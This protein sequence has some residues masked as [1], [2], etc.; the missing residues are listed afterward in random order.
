MSVNFDESTISYIVGG[1]KLG[2]AFNFTPGTELYPS[3]LIGPSPGGQTVEWIGVSWEILPLVY[4]EL[5]NPN[6]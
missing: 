5:G 6:K 4:T 1:K 3:V 2:I